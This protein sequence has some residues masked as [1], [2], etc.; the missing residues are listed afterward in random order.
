MIMLGVPAGPGGEFGSGETALPVNP[1]GPSLSLED[2]VVLND[3]I[4]AFVRAGIP[5]DVGLSG[6]ASRCDGLLRGVAERIADRTAQGQSLPEAIAAEGSAV[7]VEYRAL[8]MAGLRTGRLPEVLTSI[9]ELGESVSRLMRQLRLALVYPAIVLGLAYALFVGLMLFLVPTLW[10]THELFRTEESLFLR[11]LLFASN[12][13]ELWGIGL[14]AAV[15]VLWVFLRVWRS[16][17]GG[18]PKSMDGFGWLPGA[19]DI[20]VAR[21]A[22][23]LSVLVQYGVPFPEAARLSGDAARSGRIRTASN[24]L[25]RAVESGDSVQDALSNNR[26]LPAFLKWLMAIGGQQGSLAASL[27]QAAGVYEQRALTRL[28]RFR[29]IVPP[30]IVLVFGGIITLTYGLS[31]FIPMTELLKS[32]EGVPR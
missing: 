15:G 14:P 21:F 19:R 5:L 10:R 27:R 9:S 32:L 12:S 3:E 20:S 7:P 6:T 13:V 17:F 11:G 1:T 30:T 8:L 18:S 23:V 29:R 4:R 24:E 2:F 22:H 16:L 25:A 28:D 31:V 26:T